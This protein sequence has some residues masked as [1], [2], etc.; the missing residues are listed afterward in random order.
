MLYPTHK[1]Y[2]ILWGLLMIPVAVIIGLIP[3]ISSSMRSFDLVLIL[4]TLYMGMSGALFGS[5]FPDIDSASSIPA[6]KHPFIRKIFIKTGVKHRGKY[7]H[8]FVTIAITFGLVYMLVSFGGKRL[9]GL[10]AEGHPI[11]NV[12]V[13]LSVLFFIHMISSDIVETFQWIANVKKNKKMWAILDKGRIKYSI[14]ISLI[15]LLSLVITGVVNI[16][17]LLTF[18]ISTG[19]ALQ[20]LIMLVVVLKVYVLFAWAGAFSHLFADMTTKSGV[21]LFGKNLAPAKVML[22]IKK[23]PLIGSLLVPTEFRTG[24][25]WED[26]NN[27]V[28]TVLCIPASILALL[29]LI[30]FNFTEIFKMVGIG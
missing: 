1:K 11:L 14:I 24:S 26:F 20:M 2:G 7:S 5:R 15:I 23:I 19:S 9:I 25:K 13:Y 27:S 22:K 6:R 10:I 29:F 3:S 8:D 4:L 16:K 30:G 18:S 21:N 17:G 28:V 12:L